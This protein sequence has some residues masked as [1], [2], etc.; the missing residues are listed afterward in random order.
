[1]H[2]WQTRVQRQGVDKKSAVECDPV[3]QDDDRLRTIL[4]SVEGRR[5][6][7]RPLD[8]ER[9]DVDAK[10]VRCCLNLDH[11]QHCYGIAGIDHDRHPAQPGGCF[12]Q[13][14]DS[15]ASKIG[16]LA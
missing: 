3:A 1:M 10:C 8:F 11:R 6:I 9:D 2:R 4:H 16:R 12:A 5:D 7:L 15:F 14:L 13:E